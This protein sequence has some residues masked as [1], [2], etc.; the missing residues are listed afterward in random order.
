MITQNVSAERRDAVRDLLPV[1]AAVLPF[2]AFFGALAIQSGLTATE[3]LFA[4]ATIF[5]GA[6]QYAALDLMG[7]KVPAWAIVLTVFAVNFRHVLYSA[8]IGRVMQRFSTVQKAVGFFFLVDPLFASAEA[9]AR[10]RQITPT[11]YF[12][13]AL[14]IYCVWMAGNVAGVLF[15]RLIEDPAAYGFDFILPIYFTGLIL[16]FRGS[17]RFWIIMVV[18]GLV[19]IALWSWIGTPWNITVGGLAGLVLA[20]ALS[21]PEDRSASIGE[22]DLKSVDEAPHV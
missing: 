14:L 7:Q 5:A 19:S 10:Q 4:S 21:R 16:A 6:S 18:S 8:S 13:Y 17:N 3:A 15:G 22:S 20:A 12:T 9:R 1:L 2:A 11:Y